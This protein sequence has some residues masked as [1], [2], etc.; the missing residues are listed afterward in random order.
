MVLVDTS[1]WIGFFRDGDS[2]AAAELGR[3]LDEGRAVTCGLVEAELLPGLKSRERERIRVWMRALPRLA[4]PDEVWRRC[5]ALAFDLV[6][7][8]EYD[9][10]AADP[11]L[12]YRHLLHEL[13]GLVRQLTTILFYRQPVHLEVQSIITEL[14]LQQK[15]GT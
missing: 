12:A 4:I 2:A 3:L 8:G 6:G 11:S 9:E 5:L 15:T 10:D 1:V 7:A 14:I 13:D